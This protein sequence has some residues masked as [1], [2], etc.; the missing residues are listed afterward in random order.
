MSD[1]E[2]EIAEEMTEEVPAFVKEG[3]EE[4]DVE[5]PGEDVSGAQSS[6]FEDWIEPAKGVTLEI[7][8]AL[9]D[10]YTPEGGDWKTRSL[11]LY[12]RVDKD[13]IDG[14]GRYA[15]KMFFPRM[16]VTVNRGGTGPDGKP[17]NFSVNAQG[18]PTD[19]Y[20]PRTGGAF[21][22]YNET[23]TA[24]GFPNNPAPANNKPFRDSLVGRKLVADIT[25]KHR[26]VKDGNKYVDVPDEFENEL[27][28]YRPAK[29][30]VVATETSEAAI[31]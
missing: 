17:Y 24:L 26:Q 23:L 21:G 13:G 22:A 15:G 16:T 2:N 19:W 12:L 30:A 8:K 18:K 11:K 27:T 3:T 29:A 5:I 31:A 20:T 7:T 9:I 4:D 25:K 14:K 6:S 28:R 1:D 10:T